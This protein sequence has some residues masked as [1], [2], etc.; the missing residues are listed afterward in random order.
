MRQPKWAVLAILGFW[1]KMTLTLSRLFLSE[2][3]RA[4]AKAVLFPSGPGSLKQKN[5]VLL[6]AKSRSTMT[7]SKPP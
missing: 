2:D 3:K 5:R 7:S 1:L 6:R 4:L